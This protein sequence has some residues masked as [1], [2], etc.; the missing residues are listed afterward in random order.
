MIVMAPSCQQQAEV[1]LEANRHQQ[2]VKLAEQKV[3][4]LMEEGKNITLQRD[5]LRIDLALTQ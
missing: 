5:K 3:K 4:E 2:K 1:Q